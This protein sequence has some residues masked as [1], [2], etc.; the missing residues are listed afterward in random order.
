MLQNQY[1]WPEEQRREGVGAFQFSM[2]NRMKELNVEIEEAPSV[3]HPLE[4][5][6]RL[7]STVTQNFLKLSTNGNN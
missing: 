7:A 2:L 4:A 5:I 3:A 6:K 1:S